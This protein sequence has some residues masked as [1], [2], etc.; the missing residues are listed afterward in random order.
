MKNYRKFTTPCFVRVEDE[1]TRNELLVWLKQIGYDSCDFLWGNCIKYIRCWTTPKG[2]SKAVGYPC[3]RV[4]ITDIDCNTN[5]DLFKALAAMLDG[6]EITEQYMIATG[7]LYTAKSLI[8]AFQSPK[9][10]AKKGQLIK[11][12]RLSG[13]YFDHLRKATAIEIIEHFNVS[14]K[15]IRK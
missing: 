14:I 6:P 4:K 11:A 9:L 3:K 13:L 5:I 15:R 12:E 10:V 2:I 8:Q 7:D 1:K